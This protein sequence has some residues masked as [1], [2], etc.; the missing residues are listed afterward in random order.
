MPPYFLHTLFKN[1]PEGE[2]TKRLHFMLSNM[3]LKGTAIEDW[4]LY[5]TSAEQ[6]VR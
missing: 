5:V 3:D 2:A 6:Q 1:A 4:K